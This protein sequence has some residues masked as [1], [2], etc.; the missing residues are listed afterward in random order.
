MN[1]Q[2]IDL[3]YQVY[4]CELQKQLTTDDFFHVD[5][6]V[7]RKEHVYEIIS[8]LFAESTGLYPHSDYDSPPEPNKQNIV[9]EFFSLT[10]YDREGNQIG[11]FNNECENII[12]N[13]IKNYK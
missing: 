6:T 11:W 8:T 13:A 5:V 1:K 7:E 12:T 3:L 9:V 2:I 4:I 10:Q